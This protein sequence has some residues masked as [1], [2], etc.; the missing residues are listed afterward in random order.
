MGVA[1]LLKVGTNEAIFGYLQTFMY[2]FLMPKHVSTFYSVQK[3]A[4][5]AGIGPFPI[6]SSSSF[7][8]WTNSELMRARTSY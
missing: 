4:N 1:T 3:E 5:H 6:F 2:A 7:I 8:E